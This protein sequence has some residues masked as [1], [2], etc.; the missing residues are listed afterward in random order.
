MFHRVLPDI[1]WGLYK[2]LYKPLL[3][4][5]PSALLL[6]YLDTHLNFAHITTLVASVLLYL[7]VMALFFYKSSYLDEFERKI[8]S[9]IFLFK[10]RE[11]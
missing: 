9:G 10:R 11:C 8:F 3:F 6:Y 5:L 4:S 7:A 1:G 2:A